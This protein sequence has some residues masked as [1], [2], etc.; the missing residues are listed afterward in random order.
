M[1]VILTWDAPR[2]AMLAVLSSHLMLAMVL[3]VAAA[4]ALAMTAWERRNARR[5][6]RAGG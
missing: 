1:M 5:A 3:I 6:L 2:D 4:G